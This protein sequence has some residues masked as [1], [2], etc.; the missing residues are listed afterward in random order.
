L[1]TDKGGAYLKGIY[2]IDRRFLALPSNIR[3]G[4]RIPMITNAP[5]YYDRELITAENKL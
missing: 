2:F 1:V 5:A 3:L 4:Y